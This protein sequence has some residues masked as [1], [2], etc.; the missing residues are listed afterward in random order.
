[1]KDV[2]ISN[3]DV[4]VLSGHKKALNVSYVQT[5]LN[6]R[7]LDAWHLQL[8]P[9]PFQMIRSPYHFIK[10]KVAFA[11]IGNPVATLGSYKVLNKGRFPG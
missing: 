6:N 5:L 10:L 2:I 7:R 4:R 1:M 8:I 3:F 11:G 9:I